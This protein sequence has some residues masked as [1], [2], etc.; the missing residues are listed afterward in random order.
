[1][2]STDFSVSFQMTE[3]SVLIT[4]ASS[5]IGRASAVSFANAGH[6]VLAAARREVRLADLVSELRDAGSPGR[7]TPITL[8]VCDANSIGR[9]AA[10][11]REELQGEAPDVIINNAGFALSGAV[12]TLSKASVLE[13]FETNVFGPLELARAF[14]PA[15]RERRRG[16]V[17]NT[18]SGLGRFTIPGMGGYCASKYAL[19][20]LSDAMRMELKGFGIQV[21]LVEPGVVATEIDEGIRAALSAD[22]PQDYRRMSASVLR[23]LESE[24]EKAI[25]AE[26]VARVMLSAATVR[27]P[28]A[29]YVVPRAG[30][31]AIGLLTTLPARIADRGKT[32]RMKL[33]A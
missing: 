3:K 17:I 9:A 23:Y 4:G 6:H 30:S 15:M 26:D 1:V 7:V 20:A 21:V 28:R 33:S 32:Q 31:V 24:N 13:Q 12:E 27:K 11:T 14:L 19:E 2:I 22:V 25:P 29:R 5:G 16:R 18:S 8:D 10:R